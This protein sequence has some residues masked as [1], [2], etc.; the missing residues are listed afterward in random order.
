MDI[1]RDKPRRWDGIRQSSS[2]RSGVIAVIVSVNIPVSGGF[3]G[4]GN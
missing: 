3:S 4:V 1:P 2:N